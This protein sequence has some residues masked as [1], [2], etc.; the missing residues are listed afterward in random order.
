MVNGDGRYVS[1]LSETLTTARLTL[2][3]LSDKT[4]I[5][6]AGLAAR[7]TLARNSSML[8]GDETR[9][10]RWL[11]R[12]GDDAT[13]E[14]VTLGMPLVRMLTK[15]EHRRRSAWSSSILFDDLLQEGL[16]GLLRGLRAYT[17]GSSSSPTHYLGQWIVVEMHRGAE[18]MDNDFTVPYEVAVR[19]RRIRAITARLKTEFNREPTS[20][21]IVAA[22]L[23][24][25]MTQG[26]GPKL[27]RKQPRTT[28]KGVT[29]A[30]VAAERA[31][32]GRI[33]LTGRVTRVDDETAEEYENR[34]ASSI[35]GVAED[36][37]GEVDSKTTQPALQ[38]LLERTMTL[39]RMPTEQQDIIART[40]GLPPYT[41]VETDMEIGRA[42][43]V[44]SRQVAAVVQEFRKEMSTPHGPF[45]A[46]CA[47][48][49]EET[50]ADLGLSWVMTVLG[51]YDSK[52][53]P[54]PKGMTV[55]QSR[56]QSKNRKTSTKV[57]PAIAAVNPNAAIGT[58]LCQFHGWVFSALYRDAQSVPKEK[59]CPRCGAVSVR[60]AE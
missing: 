51:R 50:L 13:E 20:D 35:H 58:F 21:E 12:A 60:C 25:D 5:M 14:L 57:P 47:L 29:L 27:G 10:L 59:P 40:F 33:G 42:L 38:S 52:R 3:I 26:R 41:D 6:R 31:D 4:P 46:V 56:L 36:P 11:V 54:R 55:L 28:A 34:T 32:R 43:N 53:A 30:D 18:R 22:S 9:K 48:E 49:T 16:I 45:H 1:P 44:S 23:D 17:P 39:L 2:D 8:T 15:K 24:L 37:I 19:A 7:E